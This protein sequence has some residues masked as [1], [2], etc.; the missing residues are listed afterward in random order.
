MNC[1]RNIPFYWDCG[2]DSSEN[3]HSFCFLTGDFTLYERFC[4]RLRFLIR[5]V[6]RARLRVGDPVNVKSI[7]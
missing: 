5:L 7:V 2:K 4:T 6:R 1:T 3:E